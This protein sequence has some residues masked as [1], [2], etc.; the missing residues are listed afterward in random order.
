M[1]NKYYTKL[2]LES[3]DSNYEGLRVIS[4][5]EPGDDAAGA[6]SMFDMFRTIFL[7]CHS[8]SL[9]KDVVTDYLKDAHRAEVTFP[10][11]EKSNG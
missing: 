4:I 6:Y 9:L 7:G 1:E 2:T 10:K 8:E 11:Y 5:T 3:I